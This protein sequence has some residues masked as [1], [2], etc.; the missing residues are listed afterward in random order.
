MLYTFIY[1][2][3]GTG[4]KIYTNH[5]M[6]SAD[7]ELVQEVKNGIVN[8]DDVTKKEQNKNKENKKI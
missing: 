7:V 5:A 2:H 8:A 1:R 3:K 4:R 6:N